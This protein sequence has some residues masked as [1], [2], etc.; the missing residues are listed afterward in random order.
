MNLEN[1]KRKKPD[2]KGHILER[3]ITTGKLGEISEFVGF[4]WLHTHI[5]FGVE[6]RHPNK[7]LCFCL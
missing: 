3:M 5:K 2:T 6:E 7:H 4:N 1:V